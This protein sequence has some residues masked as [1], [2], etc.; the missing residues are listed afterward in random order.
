[1]WNYGVFLY[2][3]TNPVKDNINNYC[4]RPAQSSAGRPNSPQVRAE[5]VLL[6]FSQQCC[7]LSD[8]ILPGKGKKVEVVKKIKEWQ[9]SEQEITYII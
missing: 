9:L 5:S 3:I 7:C 6:Q 4:S 8:F 1:M 2:C